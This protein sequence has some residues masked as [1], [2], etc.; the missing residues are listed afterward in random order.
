MAMMLRYADMEKE[1]NEEHFVQLSASVEEIIAS[2][3]MNIF[4]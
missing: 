2:V 1:C 4:F 3:L